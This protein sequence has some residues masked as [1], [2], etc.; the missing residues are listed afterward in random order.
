MQWST[1]CYAFAKAIF[2]SSMGSAPLNIISFTA[3]IF[4][5][6]A[7]KS[8]PPELQIVTYQQTQISD[9]LQANQEIQNFIAPYKANLDRQMDSILSY[10]PMAMTKGDTPLNTALGNMIADIVRMQ[11]E[12]IFKQRTGKTVD[13]VLLNHG[14]IRA[15]LAQGPVR[16]RDAF[17]IMPFDNEMVVVELSGKKILQMVDY[18]V[19]SRRAHPIDGL[20]IKLNR[21]G[22]LKSVQIHDNPINRSSFYTVLT[23][24]YLQNGGDN[25][26]FLTEP[27]KLYKLD[28]KIRNAMI[29]FFA[30]VDTLD[31]KFDDRFTQE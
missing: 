8:E 21:N 12:T 29:D 5:L 18:L 15:P 16:M 2:P 28:Y 22:Q 1:R 31:Y 27:V 20:K 23:S 10:N 14:G 6:T 17:E 9:S 19:K 25:M 7:C 30:A 11:G 4:C 24:D 3:I 26:E 13:I